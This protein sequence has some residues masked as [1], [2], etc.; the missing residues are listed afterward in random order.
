VVA[1]LQRTFCNK[2]DAPLAART[3]NVI[4]VGGVRWTQVDLALLRA[5]AQDSAKPHV[6]EPAVWHLRQQ[7]PAWALAM[8]EEDWGRVDA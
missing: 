7:H 3:P 8:T 4:G 6:H 2:F 1:Q 5:L